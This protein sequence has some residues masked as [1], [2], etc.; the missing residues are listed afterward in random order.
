MCVCTSVCAHA[1]AYMCVSVGS[2]GDIVTK[3]FE[4][5]GVN[6]SVGLLSV[7]LHLFELHFSH[8]YIESSPSCRI[9]L[10][11][12]DKYIKSLARDKAN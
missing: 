8:V 1:C 9:V 11:I 12:R 3:T 5:M 4:R 10:R 7:I 6:I 2:V